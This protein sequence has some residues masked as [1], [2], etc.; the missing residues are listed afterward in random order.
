MV[1]VWGLK[2]NIQAAI[3]WDDADNTGENSPM[4]ATGKSKKS[5]QDHLEKGLHCLV[6]REEANH[7]EAGVSDLML[8]ENLDNDQTMP[9]HE[10]GLL[11][12]VS[13]AIDSK[14]NASSYSRE[15]LR[16]GGLGSKLFDEVLATVKS[17]LGGRW[18]EEDITASVSYTHLTLPTSDLV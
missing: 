9:E 6:L 1:W 4:V 14:V 10:I 7:D 13:G 11:K 2:S 17:S 18:T 8:S 16:N 5:I 12:H 15:A 3:P